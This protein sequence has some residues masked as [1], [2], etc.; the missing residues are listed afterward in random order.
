MPFD[1]IFILEH[2]E[3]LQMLCHYSES[4]IMGESHESLINI[5]TKSLIL[6]TVMQSDII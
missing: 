2:T 1:A 5:I 3:P 4:L 6:I